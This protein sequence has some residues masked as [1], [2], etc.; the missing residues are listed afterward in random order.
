MGKRGRI[1][2]GTSGWSY[3]EWRGGFYAGVRQ[4]DWLSHCAAHFSGIE[5][6]A[7]FY[8]FVQ[9]RFV[10]RWRDSTPEGFVFA[11]KGHKLV[12]H[13]ARLKESGARVTS[14]RD[15]VA[16][17]AG[18]IGAVLWQLPPNLKKDADLLSGFADILKASWPDVRHVMEF[19]HTSWFDAVTECLLAERG[20]ANCLSDAANWPLWEAV[21]ADLVYVRL[22][23]HDE[24]YVTEYGDAGLAPWAERVHA[25]AAEGRDVHVYFDNTAAGAAPRDALRL[26]DM[27]A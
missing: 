23:G 27:T 7:T 3:A 21:T 26:I 18:R 9:A 14:V 6:N 11:V 15:S 24:T 1:V 16:G 19:R 25:W 4:A 2:I 12:T 17:L 13:S 5:V 10:E 22:H 20:L 8:R